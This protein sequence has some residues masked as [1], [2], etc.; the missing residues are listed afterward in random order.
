MGLTPRGT[1]RLTVGR[2]V[3]LTLTLTYTVRLKQSKIFYTHA[4]TQYRCITECPRNGSAAALRVYVRTLRMIFLC[5][6]LSV[7]T[8]QG[9]WQRQ[10][11]IRVQLQSSIT[12]IATVLCE[13]PATSQLA[14][15]ALCT[16][17]SYFKWHHLER[18]PYAYCKGAR[19][20]SVGIS[21]GYWSGV[22]DSIPSRGKRFSSTPQSSDG[23]CG[24]PSLLYSR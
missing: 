24:P 17:N 11:T 14:M 5:W 20:S 13:I 7:N 22:R 4:K 8:H 23:I 2:K 6:G 18:Q 16:A 9:D 12:E 10:E 19:N 15:K 21:T 1:G 3:T